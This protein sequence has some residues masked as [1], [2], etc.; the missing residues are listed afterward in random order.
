MA[1]SASSKAILQRS[2]RRFESTRETT[3]DDGIH[4]AA[5]LE[6][7]E[8]LRAA[9]VEERLRIA[10]QGNFQALIEAKAEEVIGARV[11]D[12]FEART[13]TSKGSSTSSP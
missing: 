5:L 6:Q 12:L 1:L 2:V 3:L 10:V 13:D 8:A 7:L 4:Q 11:W 9:G